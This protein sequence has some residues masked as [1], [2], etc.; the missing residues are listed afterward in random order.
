MNKKISI[1]IS[2]W[3]FVKLILVLLAFY[4][5]YLIKDIL[6]LFFIVI[7]L[8]ATFSPVIKKWS[9]TIGRWPAVLSVVLIFFGIIAFL[10]YLVVPPVINQ[11][12]EFAR[13]LPYYLEKISY[14]RNHF[15][16]LQTYLDSLSTDITGYTGGVV[17]FTVGIFGG[18]VTI[19]SALVL[20]I[21]LLIDEQAM[22]IAVVSIFPIT[23]REQ[24][25]EVLKKVAN[26]VGNWFRGQLT[27]A[28]IVALIYL[29]GLTIMGVPYA[30]MLAVLAGV[31]D[32]V[33]V[34]GPIVAGTVA[35]FIALADSPIKALIVI[36]FYIAVQQLENTIL[37][38]KIM[39]KAVGLSPVIIIIALLI[40]AKLMGIVG[41]VLAV[42]ISASISVLI[43]E[44]P[45]IRRVWEKS[46]A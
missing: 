25:T 21:Y 34:I 44:W 16:S 46:E 9:R 43:Q 14:F 35:A 42:P 17:N 23:Q 24:L 1:D 13:S 33:P 37:V 10:V 15:P 38:P 32:F 11:M 26:Q 20:F 19:I 18:I 27:L 6:A 12:T 29:I 2:V 39:Q 30:A 45:T 4:F 31:L 41:A 3:T 22:K 7:I 8:V 28:S 40:G 36:V 5:L